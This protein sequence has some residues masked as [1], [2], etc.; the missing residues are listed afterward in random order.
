MRKDIN[1]KRKFLI[2]R[3]GYIRNRANLSGRELSLR[4]DKSIAYIAKFDNGDFEIPSETLLNAIEICGST[5]E[6]FFF[7]NIGNYKEI[8]EFIDMFE[9]LSPESKQTLKDLMKNMK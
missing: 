6:E 2:D 4:L 1:E 5:K 8:K 9:K 7:R 3:L